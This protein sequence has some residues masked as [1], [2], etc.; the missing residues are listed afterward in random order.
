MVKLATGPSLKTLLL[1]VFLIP[2]LGMIYGCGGGADSSSSSSSSSSS[3]TTTDPAGVIDLL[4]SSPQVGSDGLSTVTLTA[5]VKS[6]K[7]VAI[8]GKT[9]TFSSASAGSATAGGTLVVTSGTTDASGAATATL[10][11]ASNKA[12]RTIT[13]TAW[14]DSISATISVD[15]SGTTLQITGQNSLVSGTATVFSIFLKDSAGKTIPNQNITLTSS[16]GNTF[17]SNPVTTNANGQADVTYTATRGG[18][19]TVTASALGAIANQSVS[20]STTDF[21]F[22]SPASG[23]EINIGTLQ[24]VTTHYALGGVPQAGVTVN[25]STT[26]GAITASAVTDASG[27]AS[28]TLW[29]TTAGQAVVTATISGLGTIQ[30][31]VEFVA[32]TASTL[33]LQ[34]SPGIISVNTT[35]STV[36]QSTIIAV[37]RDANGNLVK[38]KTVRFSLSD[39]SGGYIKQASDITNSL[40]TANTIY[41]SSTSPSVKNG[42]RIDATVDGSTATASTTLTVASKPIYVVFG[43]GNDIEDYSITQYRLPFSALVTDI[44]GNPQAGVTV[45]ASLTPVKY[46]KG[47][48]TDSGC[49]ESKYWSWTGALSICQL[50]D[51]TNTTCLKGPRLECVNEDNNPIFYAG[52]PEWLLNGVLNSGGGQTEDINGDGVLTPGNIAEVDRTATTDANGFAQ[53]YVIYTKQFAS[54]VVV[55]IEGKI[56]SYGDQTLGTTQFTLPVLRTDTGCDTSPPGQ[57]S[58][59][60]LGDMSAGNNVCTNDK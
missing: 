1:L 36:E 7:N 12:N 29:S 16:L 31:Q 20:I 40:G 46:F 49:P 30:R 39:V 44:A 54:W 57:T 27:N 60:G 8:Q 10:S 25:F 6:S 21:I 4:T 5:L 17:S 41:I 18:T 13:V 11:A 58:P 42:V 56:Y 55:K 23:A 22:S 34:A 19:D 59:F 45:T 24:T 9:V 37:V 28:V 50:W 51:S 33:S 47:Y 15:V 3:G 53:F 48:W 38:N 26:R 43:T 52:H 14:V 2:V 35:G 32:V